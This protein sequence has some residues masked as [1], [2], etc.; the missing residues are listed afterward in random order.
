MDTKVA[1]YE[2]LQEDQWMVY[3]P[4]CSSQ[5]RTRQQTSQYSSGQSIP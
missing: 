3:H 5:R 2:R 1:L 4:T